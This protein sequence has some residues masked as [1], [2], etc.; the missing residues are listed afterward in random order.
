[1]V[2][3]IALDEGK[4]VLMPNTEHGTIIK[5]AGV[6]LRYQSRSKR[7]NG[8]PDPFR[9]RLPRSLYEEMVAQAV[10]E[11]PNECCGALAG[12]VADGVG[13][14]VRRYSLV[15][16]AASPVRY[17]ADEKSLIAAFKDMRQ[18]D[19]DLLAFYHSH[20]TSAPIPSRTD[21]DMNFY[22][23]EVVCLIISLQ[24]R[25]PEVRGWWLGGDDFRP[26]A[27]EVGD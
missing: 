23:A 10:A 15:N 14:V 19:I 11:Q 22:G 2:S 20:P 26:A 25:E 7:A 3:L 4:Q 8:M 1:V 24:G 18:R 21:L 9:L 5:Q 6:F 16:A 12:T 17:H 13:R 27:W